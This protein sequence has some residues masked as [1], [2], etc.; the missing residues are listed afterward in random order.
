MVAMVFRHNTLVPVAVEQVEPVAMPQ[1][2]LQAM[3][4]LA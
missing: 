2:M 4:V 3:A 1:V